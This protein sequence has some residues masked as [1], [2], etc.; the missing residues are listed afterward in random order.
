MAAA[1]RLHVRSDQGHGG[2]ATAA[3][4]QP[5]L[6]RPRMD[7]MLAWKRGEAVFDNASLPEALAEMNRYSATPIS[8][9]ARVADL[10]V[11]GLFKT[12][13]SAGFAQAVAKLHGLAVKE[14]AGRLDLA[15]K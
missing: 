12:G 5:Q 10:R 7:Q 6:D 1:E 15:A 2:S 14:H 13:D 4:A 3:Q 11:S 9:D 8:V